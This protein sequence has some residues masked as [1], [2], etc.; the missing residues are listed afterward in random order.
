FELGN[1]ATNITLNPLL[2]LGGDDEIGLVRSALATET[3][4]SHPNGMQVLDSGVCNTKLGAGDRREADK[5]ADLD[6][7]RS[8]AVRRAAQ[9]TSAFNGQLVR[10]DYF[11]LC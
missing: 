1:V 6:V 7:I 5:G 10:P 3:C 11:D 8:D 2:L 9:R 4:K